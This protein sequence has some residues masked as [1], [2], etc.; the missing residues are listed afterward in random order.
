MRDSKNKRKRQRIIHEETDNSSSA[1]NVVEATAVDPAPFE[2]PEQTTDSALAHDSTTPRANMLTHSA[3]PAP[4]PSYNNAPQISDD[5]PDDFSGRNKIQGNTKITKALDL[6]DRFSPDD[7]NDAVLQAERKYAL[8]APA[9]LIDTA[10]SVKD[11]RQRGQR[12]FFERDEGQTKDGALRKG[13]DAAYI[14]T[15]A[16]SQVTPDQDQHEDSGTTAARKLFH[17]S[18][19]LIKMVATAEKKQKTDAPEQSPET[20]ATPEI[21]RENPAVMPSKRDI[22]QYKRVQSRHAAMQGKPPVRA[23]PKGM[24]KDEMREA[25]RETNSEIREQNR[26]P[27]AIRNDVRRQKKAERT[28]RRTSY[29]HK[30]RTGLRHGRNQNN[31][32]PI[33]APAS[34]NAPTATTPPKPTQ[35]TAP[36]ADAAPAITPPPQPQPAAISKRKTG[37]TRPKR[38]R[39]K[40]PQP[41]APPVP[42]SPLQHGTPPSLTPDNSRGNENPAPV[43]NREQPKPPK[44]KTAPPADKKQSKKS[45]SEKKPDKKASKLKHDEKTDKGNKLNFGENRQSNTFLAQGG[46]YIKGKA[47]DKIHSE[48][49]K[50]EK[51]FGNT[52][53]ESSHKAVSATEKAH[54]GI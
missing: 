27:Q 45:S 1:E 52:G 46:R 34:G 28:A 21:P 37:G 20:A 23:A 33:R 4:V 38:Q 31:N 32:A 43:A 48:I 18:A 16:A 26:P 13:L 42:I 51:E 5:A 7:K 53:L 40:K 3:A 36:K 35:P 47:A 44:K 54:G 17:G 11:V 6:I 25:I 29:R 19:D 39:H 14:A 12:L 2:V 15:Q 30:Q 41:H 22:E 24:T 50:D 8:R 49:S 10:Q 9:A